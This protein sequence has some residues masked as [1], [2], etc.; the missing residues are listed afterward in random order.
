[1][2]TVKRFFIWLAA[3]LTVILIASAEGGTLL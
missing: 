1:M 3:M 2:K